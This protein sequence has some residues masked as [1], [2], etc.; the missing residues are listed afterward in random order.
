VDSR[1]PLDSIRNL[2]VLRATLDHLDDVVRGNES[3]AWETEAKRLA[4]ETLRRG[5]RAVLE[6]PAKGLYLV[7]VTEDDRV[8]GQLM[9]TSEWS[10]WRDGTIFWIQSVYVTPA[11]RRSGVYRALHAA[12][13]SHARANGGVAVRLYVEKHNRV[14]QETYRRVGMQPAIYDLMEQGDF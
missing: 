2:R 13:L 3:M 14:A 7:A 12:V 4:P 5:V 9:V 1:R 10:D 6:D 8:L 11:A